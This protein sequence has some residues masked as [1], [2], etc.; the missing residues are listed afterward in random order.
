[1]YPEFEAALVD[2]SRVF[3][4]AMV[5][6]EVD[7]FLS[8]ARAVMRRL[9]AEIFDPGTTYEYV[10]TSPADVARGLVLDEK[11]AALELGL[12]DGVVAAVAERMRVYRIL[13]TD[14]R[15]FGALRV[16]ARF[17]KAL[18]VVP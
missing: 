17:A 1:L 9:A 3:V 18:V 4:P 8:G 15:D 7:Y 2:A 11:F 5:L 13:T 14:R 6:A 10:P 16:G 12:V